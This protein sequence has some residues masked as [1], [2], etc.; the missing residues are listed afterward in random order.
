VV[1]GERLPAVAQCPCSTST[2]AA[3]GFF[4]LAAFG[5]PAEPAASLDI[6]LTALKRRD[7]TVAALEYIVDGVW[8]PPSMARVPSLLEVLSL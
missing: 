8:Q 6:S 3:P 4:V 2:K 5:L 7:G 1:P